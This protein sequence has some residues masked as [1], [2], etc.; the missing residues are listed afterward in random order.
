MG[1]VSRYR[2]RLSSSCSGIL[3]AGPSTA[4]WP[5]RTLGPGHFR[6]L[7]H[8][9]YGVVEERH[10][11]RSQSVTLED[12]PFVAECVVAETREE[13]AYH[14]ALNYSVPFGDPLA[15]NWLEA[16]ESGGH[17]LA[18]LLDELGDFVARR[19]DSSREQDN[20]NLHRG[21]RAAHQDRR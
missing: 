11:Y 16:G 2:S 10:W 5:I 15:G 20:R 1:H 9:R 14:F 7:L 12:V 13:G 4:H 21:R 19:N 6:T 8:A 17:S 3:P 18:D